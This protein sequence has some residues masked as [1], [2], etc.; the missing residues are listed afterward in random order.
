ML[1]VLIALLVL[2]I[3]ALGFAAIQLVAMQHAEDANYRSYAMLIAQDAVERIQSNP[4]DVESYLSATPPSPPATA[5]NQACTKCA[6]TD[7]MAQLAWSASQSLP[8]GRIKIDE[9]DFNGMYCVVL[10][11]GDKAEDGAK[12]IDACMTGAGIN[13]SM[14]SNCLVMEFSR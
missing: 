10:N 14:D 11:W 2:S 9:C 12:N 3:G 5:P 13:S 1:E 4:D 6:A 7:D 8:N